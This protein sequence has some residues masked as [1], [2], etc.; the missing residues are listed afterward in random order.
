[1]LAQD[2]ARWSRPGRIPAEPAIGMRARHCV[3]L[4]RRGDLLGLLMVIDADEDLSTAD[5]ALIDARARAVATLMV[6]ERASADAAVAADDALVA[7]TLGREPGPRE[8]AH[9][10]R[11]GRAPA[12]P[13]AP[14]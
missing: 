2:V 9:G 7:D 4:R 12:A 3:P 11:R 14:D 1:V 6:G 8:R 10:H 13:P 5:R